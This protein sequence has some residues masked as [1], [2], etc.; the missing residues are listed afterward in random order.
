MHL[1]QRR[2]QPAVSLEA[3]GVQFIAA[4]ARDL[5]FVHAGVLARNRRT[6]RRAVAG[7]TMLVGDRGEACSVASALLD[8]LAALAR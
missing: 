2:V 1:R 4:N 8:E 5:T 6:L 3:F 7:A